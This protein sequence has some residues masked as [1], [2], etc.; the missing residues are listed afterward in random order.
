MNDGSSGG[1]SNN[2]CLSEKQ[3]IPKDGTGA[4]ATEKIISTNGHSEG[5]KS[6][7]RR[8]VDKKTDQVTFQ[9]FIDG[10]SPMILDYMA[11]ASSTQLIVTSVILV[12]A[13]TFFFGVP[14]FFLLV[15]ICGGV[16]MSF[17]IIRPPS[18]TSELD[19]LPWKK[20]GFGLTACEQN[21]KPLVQS[22]YTVSPGVHKVFERAIDIVIENYVESWYRD[23]SK[24]DQTFLNACRQTLFDTATSFSAQ[25]AVK[26]P[27]DLFLV[28]LFSTCNTFVVFLRE[29]QSV[30]AQYSTK[31]LI[32]I[33]D[34]IVAN[35]ESALAQM[36]D[37][38]IQKAKLRN[39]SSN[40]VQTFIPILD[41]KRSPVAL[42]A[43]EIMASQVLESIVETLSNPDSV[44]KWIIHFFQKEENL[45]ALAESETKSREKQNFAKDHQFD[46]LN[47]V[48]AYTD[49]HEALFESEPLDFTFSPED[50]K[51]IT[52]QNMDSSRND[53]LLSDS[54]SGR[55]AG[56]E[57]RRLESHHRVARKPVGKTN[58]P[59][60][61][62]SNSGSRMS[63][64]DD[65]D[66]I[67][68]SF[69]EI[70]S[71]GNGEASDA[72]SSAS[73]ASLGAS[74][75]ASPNSIPT[76][77][78]I[79][80]PPNSILGRKPVQLPTSTLY[81]SN[82]L[83][84]DSSAD[85][86][87]SK[88]LTSKPLG[89]YTLVIEP[90][91]TAPGWMAMRN[92]A[93]FE[94]L[95][96]VLQKLAVLAGITTFPEVFPPWHGVT[97]SNYCQSLQSYLQL[98]VS[99]KELADCEAMKK[100]VDKKETTSI[101]EKRWQRSPFKQAGEGVLD[102]I[103]KATTAT[104]SAKDSRKA[105]MNVLAA[106]KR[107]SMDTI[108]RTKDNMQHRKA[109][110]AGNEHF[111]GLTSSIRSFTNGLPNGS[112][113]NDRTIGYSGE[114]N[115]SVVSLASTI[116]TD[117]H[118]LPPPPSEIADSYN[119]DVPE[120][121]GPHLTG[122]FGESS[123]SLQLNRTASLQR[124]TAVGGSTSTKT[125]FVKNE[126]ETETSDSIVRRSLATVDRP[127][128]SEILGEHAIATSAE[129]G[130]RSSNIQHQ[131]LTHGETN[132]L[133]DTMFLAISEL[134]LLSNAWNVRR[135]L[136]TVLRGLLLRNGSSSVEGIRVAIQKDVINKYSSEV[137][138]ER[139][140][141]DL[142]D[143]IWPNSN[144]NAEPKISPKSEELKAEARKMFIT[145]GI[146]EA[147][148]SVMGAGASAQALE[149][150]FDSLQ[151]K[152][153]A[154][155]LVLNLLMDCLTT[156]LM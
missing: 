152:S 124:S 87:N 61:S 40:L 139:K 92:L 112:N 129:P 86:S 60:S 109:F 54:D 66:K 73:Y 88:A 144:A 145:R 1:G 55:S 29:L 95:H 25:M 128:L 8:P 121:K 14:I 5:G 106:A 34:Y 146:P 117:G 134:Y 130:D 125:E 50:E 36:L 104:S 82:I 132:S 45:Q 48:F 94:K 141:N 120:K 127:S 63:L 30:S 51:Y 79:V 27:A 136:L 23:L 97:R 32:S 31:S 20:E 57:V 64:S 11:N 151:D 10:V 21:I 69:D 38:E 150:V 80:P 96:T 83:V 123:T 89:F 17:T 135:S 111:T 156:C 133:I 3:A 131:E 85:T 103:A 28:L 115:S 110:G 154:R 15:G 68:T 58:A 119:P 93:D 74:S 70:F 98:V 59:P 62:S 19:Q 108:N 2:G 153:I 147:I 47:N 6:I 126:S 9:S 37:P 84:I 7:P 77:S 44:N 12:P 53:I 149:F 49:D 155:G 116:E 46:Q 138:I 101:G 75:V 90:A 107:Q 76:P 100:F 140:L 52:E 39:A 118:I 16:Y 122:S 81:Q 71:N 78:H 143:A 22:S 142:V 137:E 4:E 26:R 113:S 67:P 105:I 41:M 72:M 24:D 65:S 43:R 102:A 35:P 33:H 13:L 18:D 114:T 42:L 148:K 99:T 91:G 56:A